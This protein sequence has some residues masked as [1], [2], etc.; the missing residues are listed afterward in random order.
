MVNILKEYIMKWIRYLTKYLFLSRYINNILSSNGYILVNLKKRVDSSVRGALVIESSNVCNAACIFCPYPE[1]KKYSDKQFGNLNFER[2]KKI[3]EISMKLTD[4]RV[5][6]TP[7]T[8]EFFVNK[9][10]ESLLSEVYNWPN[11]LE[12]FFNTNAILLNRDKQISLIKYQDKISYIA[13]SLTIGKNNYKKLFGVDKYDRIK[14]NINDFNQILKEK[15]SKIKLIPNVHSEEYFY[16]K[17]D[18][19]HEFNV[20]KYNNFKSSNVAPKK[21]YYVDGQL[22]GDIKKN[23]NNISWPCS[24]ITWIRVASND[25]VWLCGCVA[26]ESASDSSLRIGSL[27]DSLSD[28]RNKQNSIF[29]E[30]MND[31]K[32]PSICKNCSLYSPYK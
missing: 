20:S 10:W 22:K 8:G 17:S 19:D 12:I 28:L 23:C 15:N 27:D 4:G 7:T 11:V 24:R 26:S 21:Y 1:I 13:L 14:S 31:G 25:S 2:L 5:S 32:V 16:S 6:F 30:W 9:K 29:S 3:R 18:V